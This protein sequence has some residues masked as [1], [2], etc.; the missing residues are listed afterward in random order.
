M[1]PALKYGIGIL[2]LLG[3]LLVLSLSLNEPIRTY[4]E[5]ELNE[6]VEG[7]SFSLKEVN[8]HPFWLGLELKNLTVTQ[9]A[10]PDPPVAMI[11]LW[12]A[13]LHW[14]ALLAGRIVSDHELDNPQLHITLDNAKQ[15]QQDQADIEDRGWQEAV[16]AIYPVKINTLEIIEGDITYIDADPSKPL[17]LQLVNLIAENIRNVRSPDR[18]YPST[19]KLTASVFETGTISLEGR[20]DFLAQPHF[21]IKA[22][23]ALN[24]INLKRFLPITGRYNFQLTQGWFSGSGTV[25]YAPSLTQVSLDDLLF[26]DVHLDYVDSA[27]TREAEQQVVQ[28]AKQTAD[29]VQEDPK[30]WLSA[31]R[32]KVTNSDFGYVNKDTDPEYRVFIAS[33][34][35]EMK[36]FS[37]QFTK[38]S[39]PIRLKG[40]FMGTGE[41][42][43]TGH[44]RPEA[45]SPDFD[46]NLKIE[47]T[48]L[49]PM[50]NLLKAYGGFDVA[51]G[52]FSFFSEMSIKDGKIKGY[53]KPFFK[54]LDVYHPRQDG[55]NNLLTQL[56]EG[57]VGSIS[58]LL[59]NDAREQVATKAD[60]S[61]KVGD[62][63]ASTWDVI[64]NLIRNAFFQAILPGFDQTVKAEE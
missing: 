29:K 47:K 56:Y 39:S 44:F 48:Q 59:E 36:N 40:R 26:E 21:G 8:V 6:R 46:L 4:I 3:L 61:G 55:D 11:P 28:T 13:G 14:T 52:N 63:D 57:L 35:M 24:K 53:I 34:N 58:E 2:L 50:N 17:R 22:D 20:A 45:H 49:S 33:V 10:K 9:D 60:L 41:T 31:K 32:I 5:R 38:G 64:I 25:E 18:E 27:T 62:P 23:L 30:T 51:K 42:T 7:Y 43:L 37:N 1:K 15:E 12:R 19:I 54:N 16:L